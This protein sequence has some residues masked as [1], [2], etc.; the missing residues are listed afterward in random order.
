[1]KTEKELSE[2]IVN[3]TLKIQEEYPELSDFIGEMPVT[4]PDEKCPDTGIKKLEDYY[5]SLLSL[6][7]KYEVDHTPKGEENI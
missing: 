5:D 7:Q 4:I 2:A 6:L 1:M 3:I